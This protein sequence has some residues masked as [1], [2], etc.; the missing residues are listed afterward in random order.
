LRARRDF[1]LGLTVL[2]AG[3]GFRLRGQQE[4]AFDTIH[5]AVPPNSPLGAELAR[6]IRTGS[7]AQV[8]QERDKAQAILQIVGDV[9]ERE[10]LSVNAQGRARE[11]QLRYRV[12]FRVHDGKGRDFVGPTELIVTR[13]IAFNESQVLARE[14][15]EALLFRDMQSDLVQQLMRRLAAIKAPEKSDATEG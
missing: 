7:N 8:V 9:R 11:Y 5:L 3:C 2:A 12:V 15:E 14:A 6:N 1:L 4:F 10:V 13:D